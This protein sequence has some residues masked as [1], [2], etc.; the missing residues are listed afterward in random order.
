MTMRFS[1][2]F[3]LMLYAP[4]AWSDCSAAKDASKTV[5]AGGSL[6]EIV[7]FLEEEEKIIGVDVTSNFPKATSDF[8]SI[9]YVR[10]LSTEGILS[11]K[12][13]LIL[14][15]DDMGPPLVIEQLSLTGLDVRILEEDHSSSG[16]LKKIECLSKVLDTKANDTL[17]KIDL[18]KEDINYLNKISQINKVSGIKVMLILNMQ[19]T[20]PIVAGLGTSGDGFISM[21]GASNAANQFEGWKPISSEAIIAY[22]PDYIIITNRGMSSFPDVQSLA[23]TTSLR[24]T[25]AAQNGRILQ[26]DGMAMLGFGTRTI[27]TAIQFAKLFSE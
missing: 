14:G 26:E 11:L 15:E 17:T 9:G 6:T 22:N 20:S 5:I 4:I 3:L 2:F 10:A 18:V 23:N 21:T 1:S 13:T 24:L 19:G 27:S 7:Y 25:S 8:P 12:P 16:I